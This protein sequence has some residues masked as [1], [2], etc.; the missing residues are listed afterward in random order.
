MVLRLA[1]LL[2][3]CG[4]LAFGIFPECF[5]VFRALL[6]HFAVVVG[7]LLAIFPKVFWL[8]AALLICVVFVAL[9]FI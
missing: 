8:F 7:L 4:R 3:C 6:R 1:V 2:R 9:G 5:P